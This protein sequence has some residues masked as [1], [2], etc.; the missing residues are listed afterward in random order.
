MGGV[1][2][3]VDQIPSP[4]V[5]EGVHFV[6]IARESLR[7]RE[8]HRIKPRPNAGPLLVAECPQSALGGNPRAGQDENIHAR[9]LPRDCADSHVLESELERRIEPR[10]FRGPNANATGRHSKYWR[11]A[12]PPLA[13]TGT[14]STVRRS[15]LA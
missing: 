12:P 4:G 13:K 14:R 8:L 2:R 15:S 7:R 10:G 6:G 3:R 9:S 1:G 5:V 11:L